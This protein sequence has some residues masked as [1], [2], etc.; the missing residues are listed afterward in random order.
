MLLLLRTRQ[1]AGTTPTPIVPVDSLYPPLPA[2][3]APLTWRWW[4]MLPA[5]IRAIDE[6]LGYPFAM[7]ID[8]IGSQLD[9]LEQLIDSWHPDR[10][11]TGRSA[12]LDPDIAPP[13]VLAWLAPLGGGDVTAIS[14]VPTKRAII[15]QAANGYLA[16]AADSYKA[17]VQPL[18]AGQR[19]VTVTTFVGGDM[20][21]TDVSVYGPEVVDVDAVARALAIVKPAG[22]VLTLNVTAGITI[23]ELTGTIDDLSITYPDAPTIDDFIHIPPP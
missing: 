5:A 7:W 14:D 23:D 21:A 8:L 3:I 11:P 18:L 17:A 19:R 13:G 9:E 10:N 4:G 22:V 1:S 15:K 2:E 16:G 12:L 6:R 20:W